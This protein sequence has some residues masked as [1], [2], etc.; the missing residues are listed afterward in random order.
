ML[1]FLVIAL[2]FLLP[3]LRFIPSVRGDSEAEFED[4]ILVGDP[5][6]LT[7][8]SL[9]ME[10]NTHLASSIGGDGGG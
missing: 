10:G 3:Y 2:H 7:P 8:N 9:E 1:A 4:A 6:S 5:E